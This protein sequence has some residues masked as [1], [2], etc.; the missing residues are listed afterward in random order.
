MGNK[1]L[2]FVLDLL[3]FLSMLNLVPLALVFIHQ[4]TMPIE[5]VNFFGILVNGCF[6]YDLGV[7]IL[8]IFLNLLLVAYLIIRNE[9][10]DE[11]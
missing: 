1:K 6:V 5:K 4:V 2:F 7:V 10:R 8:F 3:V 11:K 9:K